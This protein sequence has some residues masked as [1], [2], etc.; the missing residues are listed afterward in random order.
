MSEAF[1]IPPEPQPT[2]ELQPED[3]R[4]LWHL[5]QRSLEHVEFDRPGA[6]V[7]YLTLDQDRHCLVLSIEPVSARTGH[8]TS[9]DAI[10]HHAALTRRIQ[11]A[12][13]DLAS[14]P[15]VRDTD[16]PMSATFMAALLNALERHAVHRLPC[17]TKAG[18]PIGVVCELQGWTGTR[19]QHARVYSTGVARDAAGTIAAVEITNDED[20][21]Y[22]HEEQLPL[23]FEWLARTLTL[24]QHH[25]WT[26]WDGDQ[27]WLTAT[28]F[29]KP[30]Q[31]W[32]R[33]LQLT[34]EPIS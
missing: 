11:A 9:P 13:P 19:F 1:K 25:D 29:R 26:P 6:T 17:D 7:P 8:Y 23:V 28:W 14:L 20:D 30:P 31:A 33:L 32:H 2:E 22:L 24:H 12:M 3:L 21:L 27:R 5:N 16:R 10:E 34:A 15:P 18:E 4:W